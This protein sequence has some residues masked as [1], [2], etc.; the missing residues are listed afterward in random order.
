MMRKR[1]LVVFIAFIFIF[2]NVDALE[3]DCK[4]N[5]FLVNE[6]LECNLK[7]N[8]NSNLKNISFDVQA[9]LDTSVK[10]NNYLVSQN[11]NHVT[12]DFQSNYSQNIIGSITFK[13]NTNTIIGNNNVVFSNIVL[14]DSEDNEI[15]INDVEKTITVNESNK[16]GDAFLTKII[17]DGVEL[18]DFSPNKFQYKNIYVNKQIVFIDAVR[19]SDKAS[20]NGLGNV[21][22]R[23]Y[24]KGNC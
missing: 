21:L 12:I 2:I 24:Y 8:N 4:N 9:N 5:S 16:S 7:L 14:V 6:S 18:S 1:W 20:V 13:A 15:G 17:V 23:T 22:V 11:G 10:S 3:I 19:H